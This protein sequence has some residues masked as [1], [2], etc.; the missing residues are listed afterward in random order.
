MNKLADV[1]IIVES[2]RLSCPDLRFPYTHTLY[3]LVVRRARYQPY[4]RLL[5]NL[6]RLLL[7][8]A[9]L[10]DFNYFIGEEEGTST[11]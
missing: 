5:V 7:A 3:R 10:D 1:I 9:L 8:I 2:S 4:G 6:Q 11:I